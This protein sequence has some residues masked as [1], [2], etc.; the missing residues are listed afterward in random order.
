M[1]TSR[2]AARKLQDEDFAASDD[3]FDEMNPTS[4]PAAQRARKSAQ[5]SKGSKKQPMERKEIQRRYRERLKQQ[6]ESSNGV[7]GE[8]VTEGAELSIEYQALKAQN[9]ALQMCLAYADEL[10]TVLTRCQ[11]HHPRFPSHDVAGTVF[12]IM[13]E[14]RECPEQLVK[15]YAALPF[16]IIAEREANDFSGIMD[17]S[18]GEWEVCVST[19]E[20]VENRLNMAFKTRMR[21]VQYI[22]QEKPHLHLQMMAWG[23]QPSADSPLGGS[24]HC[25]LQAVAAKM[26]L[27]FQQKEEIRSA[28]LEYCEAAKNFNFHLQQLTSS[29]RGMEGLSLGIGQN[30]QTIET[31]EQ[32]WDSSR[33]SISKYAQDML[34]LAKGASSIAGAPQSLAIAYGRLAQAVVFS[35]NAIER[36]KLFMGTRP[37]QPDHVQLCKLILEPQE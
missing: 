31:M 2:A 29:T 32:I 36:A 14:G 16:S 26:N 22:S 28:W 12:S 3:E 19:R 1:R 25:A 7:A 35:L 9:E 8:I 21:F 33:I 27:T 37:Y 5:T 24:A 18:V 11:L 4:S 30:S 34:S 13:W 15:A 17:V 10:I 6:H 23:T 20:K